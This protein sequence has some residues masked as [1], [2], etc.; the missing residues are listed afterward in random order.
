MLCL[1]CIVIIAV[2]SG[3]RG[4]FSVSLCQLST[5]L[6]RGM[7]KT[8]PVGVAVRRSTTGL[9]PQRSPYASGGISE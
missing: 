6:H 7:L 2:A 4:N 3:Y 5:V 8:Q 9:E 1:S